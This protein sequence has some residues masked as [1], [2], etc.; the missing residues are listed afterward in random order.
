MRD[1]TNKQKWGAP[2]AEPYK[3]VICDNLNLLVGTQ[4]LKK[5][6]HDYWTTVVKK[7]LR[8][9]FRVLLTDEEKSSLMD[10]RQNMEMKMF[11]L[12]L[13]NIIGA[14]INSEAIK[15][16]WKSSS[17]DSSTTFF[18]LQSDI[19][20]MHPRVKKAFFANLAAGIQCIK[21][22]K[23]LKAGNSNDP[24]IRQTVMRQLDHAR[25]VLW[26]AQTMVPSCPVVNLH[27]GLVMSELA[28][29]KGIPQCD[30]L[31]NISY[32][33]FQASLDS[34]PLSITYRAYVGALQTHALLKRNSSLLEEAAQLEERARKVEETKEMDE[35]LALYDPSNTEDPP[36]P[37]VPS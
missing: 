28:F 22:S 17:E 19:I 27:C 32:Q 29:L 36:K 37:A 15:T 35:R 18:F 11:F 26:E 3:K 31:F 14:E 1:V 25:M 8:Q 5:A 10:L 4:S 30:S 20:A 24:I 34:K 2:A 16:M 7:E 12:Y 6:A 33:L 23:K 9:Q 13:S 21:E